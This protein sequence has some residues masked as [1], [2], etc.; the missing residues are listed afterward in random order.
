VCV[1]GHD[2]VILSPRDEGALVAVEGSLFTARVDP[3]TSARPGAPL[4][5][6]LDP[7]RFH[8]FAPETVLRLEPDS[9]PAALAN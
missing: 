2:A 6:A 3:G 5:L 4:R 1:S 8:Y 7:S 9:A